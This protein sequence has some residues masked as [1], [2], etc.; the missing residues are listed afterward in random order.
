MS[1]I[2]LNKAH[3]N[4]KQQTKKKMLKVISLGNIKHELKAK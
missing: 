2:G 1:N 4:Q 3:F